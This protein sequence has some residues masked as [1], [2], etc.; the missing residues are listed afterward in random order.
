VKRTRNDRIWKQDSTRYLEAEL[1][2]ERI[3]VA[4]DTY[5]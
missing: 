5:L 2:P 1:Q 3:G 4:M